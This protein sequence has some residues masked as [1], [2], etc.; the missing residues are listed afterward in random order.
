VRTIFSGKKRPTLFSEQV[1]ADG[2]FPSPK[3]LP[4]PSCLLPARSNDYGEGFQP[5]EAIGQLDRTCVPN[6]RVTVNGNEN[7]KSSDLIPPK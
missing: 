2:G 3:F 1:S 6:K 7:R 5:K 4:R